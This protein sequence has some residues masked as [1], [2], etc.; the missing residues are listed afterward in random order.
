MK[1]KLKFGDYKD[2]LEATQLE[3][4]V[5]QPEKKKLDGIRENY[6]EFVKNNILILKS[7]QRFKREKNLFTEEVNRVALSANDDKR[8]QSIDS[9][10]RCAHG[11]SKDLACKKEE[12]KCNNTIEQYKNDWLWLYYKRKHRRKY[13]GLATN[14]WSFIQNIN[15]WRLRIW[16][17]QAHYLIW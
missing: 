15:S 5:N 2:C 11:T 13:F 17:K 12:S 4:K 3:N 6:K 8:I 9:I 7:Q 1:H 10:E 14:S 16:K